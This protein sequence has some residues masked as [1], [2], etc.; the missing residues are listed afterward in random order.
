MMAG[1]YL[2]AETS[3]DTQKATEEARQA[4]LLLSHT[5][6]LSI[7]TERLT[8]SGLTETQCEALQAAVR[9]NPDA[10]KALLFAL[11][12]A[13]EEDLNPTEQALWMLAADFFSAAI[14]ILPFM[15]LPIGEAR[16]VSAA[17]TI[18]LLAM[19]GIGRARIGNRPMLRTVA[20][21]V[22]M[23]IAAALAG[24]GIGMLFNQSFGG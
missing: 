17:T 9:G 23:G 19:L 11:R 12:G 22:A 7:C 8:A 14:P 3:R 21:T 5:A 2:E 1:A 10:L 20:E 13:P 4:E 24:V 6:S 16:V 18:L 15:L